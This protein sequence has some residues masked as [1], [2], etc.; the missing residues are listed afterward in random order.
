ME[1]F[2][3]Y[4]N[5][6]AVNSQIFPHIVH[7]FTDTN[8]A[9]REQ[10]VKVFIM[11][12]RNRRQRCMS[13]CDVCP[14]CCNHSSS[15]SP[16]PP[17]VYVAARSQA[18]WNQLEPGADASLCP[19]TGQRW[20]RP[21]PVQHHRLSGQNCLLPQC[22]GRMLSHWATLI[23]FNVINISVSKLSIDVF[24]HFSSHRPDSVFWFLLSPEQQKIL[25]QLHGLLVYWALP[26]HTTSTAWQRSL[27][28]SCPHSVPLLLTL[29]RVWGTRYDWTIIVFALWGSYTILYL[30]RVLR[31]L[32]VDF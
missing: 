31:Y 3:Q 9:I 13:S 14:G 2:I 18:E 17:P 29:I 11:P 26:P 10:T 25:F 12:K 21:N 28:V 4:L 19:A 1:Q 24:G 7:G 30:Y 16:L 27:H 6:A 15:F 20:T 22:W 5:E 23:S 32:S 8:P